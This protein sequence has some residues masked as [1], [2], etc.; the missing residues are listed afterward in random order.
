MESE[1]AATREGVIRLPTSASTS[2][3]PAASLKGSGHS[4]LLFP[5]DGESA[6]RR[7]ERGLRSSA[8]EPGQANWA[9]VP[10]TTP[11]K[12]CVAYWPRIC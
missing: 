3:D 5:A 7:P 10:P 2:Q 11:L 9:A 6:G 8:T 1:S 4:F 12:T